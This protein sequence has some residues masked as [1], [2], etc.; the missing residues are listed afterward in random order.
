MTTGIGERLKSLRVDRLG[1]GRKELAAQL[2]AR[3]VPDGSP[4]S[5]QRYETGERTPRLDY[6]VALAEIGEISVA[7]VLGESAPTKVLAPLIKVP[8]DGHHIL[9]QIEYAL[10][11][12]RDGDEPGGPHEAFA[13]VEARVMKM[14]AEN[15]ISDEGWAYWLALRKGAALSGGYDV[16]SKDPADPV[17]TA[18]LEEEQGAA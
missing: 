1:L 18:E 2:E 17:G 15:R 16:D 4:A 9:G 6:V 8:P 11:L 13:D 14:R 5:I 7:E 10:D 3:G 12:R